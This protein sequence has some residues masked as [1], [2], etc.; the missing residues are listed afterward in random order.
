[1]KL[2]ID[3]SNVMTVN[4]LTGIQRV[5]REITV[6]LYKRTDIETVLLSYS[7][8]GDVFNIVDKEAFLDYFDKGAGDKNDLI[9][10]RKIKIEDIES[11]SVFLDI[12]SVW[13]T[14]LRRSYLLPK[15]KDNGVKIAVFIHDV[16]SI[17]HPQYSHQ[18]TAFFFM[19]Y[20][21]A[22]MIYADLIITST[23]TTLEAI[24]KLTLDL[25]LKEKKGAVVTFGSDFKKDER[26]E[27]AV[28]PYVINKIK[29]KKYALIVGTIEPRKNHAVALRAFE[30]K[31]FSRDISLVFAGR[32]GWNIEEFKKEIENHPQLNKKL[33][34]ISGANDATIDYLYKNA[35]VTLFP[36]FNEGFGLPLIE[37]IERG[38]PMIASNC[39][40]LREI[41]KDFC[42]YFEPNNEDE[43]IS[44]IENFLD[45]P[46][47]YQRAKDHLK[48]YTPVTWDESADKMAKALLCLDIRSEFKIPKIRQMVILSA[49]EEML[50]ETIPFI[51]SFMPFIEEIVICCPDKAVKKIEQGY[52]GRI[53]LSFL[54]DS[55]VLNGRTLPKDHSCRNFFL[56]CLAFKNKIINDAFI[57]CDDDYRPLCP[58]SHDV[59]V[60][61]GRYKAYYCYDINRWQGTSGEPTSYDNCMFR[62]SK[63]LKD[64]QYPQKQ[65]SSHMPQAVDKRIF[66]EMLDSHPGLENTGCCEWSTYFNYAQFFYPD[67][68]EALPYISMCWPGAPTDWDM[69]YIPQMFM[70]ENYYPEQYEKGGI[71]ELFSTVYNENIVNEN[72]Q[73]VALYINRQLKHEAGKAKFDMFKRNY[74]YRY[75]E[76]PIF[77]I[78]A[79]EEHFKIYLPQYV[80]IDES[81]CTKIRFSVFNPDNRKFR[82]EYYYT[83]RNGDILTMPD[84][85]EINDVKYADLSVYGLKCKGNYILNVTCNDGADESVC[86]CQILL[87]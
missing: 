37:S 19:D 86:Q 28:S 74:V 22:Y 60:Q 20:I 5:V 71:F 80:S 2:Y 62:T 38:T 77:L 84:G 24:N 12:D 53:K 79:S 75:G 26:E 21:G 9:N 78:D 56:R 59:F 11:S 81:C 47:E 85:F 63:F 45:N 64:N 35:Y 83:K 31:L 1:M 43:L 29:I 66:L 32:F 41:G 52:N 10:Y 27:G 69:K 72:V 67:K 68:F 46:K 58:I 30:K 73:K 50:L 4:F 39:Q 54:T 51:E 61:D 33:I 55:V 48:D 13:N 14:R 7:N 15:L 18:N 40:V 34:H 44:H 36:T 17:T 23:E 57:M 76:D 42:G 87:E 65:Y 49:R 25:G 6:R 70:F 3:V 16:L 8:E 82:L